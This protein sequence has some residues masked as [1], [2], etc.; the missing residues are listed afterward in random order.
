MLMA[1]GNDYNMNAKFRRCPAA[2]RE[3]GI[4]RGWI[5][6]IYGGGSN[7]GSSAPFVIVGPG[8]GPVKKITNIRQPSALGAFM[9]TLDGWGMYSRSGWEFDADLDSDGKD[10]SNGSCGYGYIKYN[11]AL[12]KVHLDN[13]SVVYCDG[14]VGKM[15]FDEFLDP[16]NPV[17]GKR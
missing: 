1:V 14:H 12:P 15:R 10:D 13:S 3:N 5:G 16:G 2:R 6:C 17:W 7:W 8:Y 9:D 4:L 11:W